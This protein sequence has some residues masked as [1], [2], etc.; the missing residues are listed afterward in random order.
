[1]R[2]HTTKRVWRISASLLIALLAGLMAREQF[3]RCNGAALD[4]VLSGGHLRLPD[5]CQLTLDT[6]K[7]VTGTVTIEGGRLQGIDNRLFHV[8]ADASLT[9]R[10]VWLIG[11]HTDSHGGALY[12][13]GTT[14][15]DNV[16]FLSNVAVE[17]G[18][19]HSSGTL[20][21][22]SGRLARNRA[23]LGGAVMIAAG[24]ARFEGVL[25]EDNI[26]QQFGGA[27]YIMDGEV[28]LLDTRIL[29]N[30]A[31][32]AGAI[33]NRGILTIEDSLINRNAAQTGAAGALANGPGGQMNIYDS[34]IAFN[35]AAQDAGAIGNLGTLHLEA[36]TLAN[37]VAQDVGGG[38]YNY[39]SAVA[40]VQRS[41][42]TNNTDRQGSRSS[43]IVNYIERDPVGRVM[44]VGNYWGAVDGP[45]GDGPGSGDGIFGM[46]PTAYTPWLTRAPSTDN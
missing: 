31:P 40:N 42:I 15:L 4:A 7:I 45:S 11:G 35:R 33:S 38:L 24:T 12:N 32:S 14:L 26:A 25:F 8:Q 2:T 13:A 27:L 43:G 44:A 46:M 23:D 21:M 20:Q 37:N 34:V 41:S 39:Y 9:L 18:A 16:Q 30:T 29:R 22:M 6:E 19:I 28:R 1:M 3:N 36:V 10:N 5:N 17:G